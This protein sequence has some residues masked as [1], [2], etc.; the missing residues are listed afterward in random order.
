MLTSPTTAS[1]SWVDLLEL[2]QEAFPLDFTE[3]SFLSSSDTNQSADNYYYMYPALYL[4]SDTYQSF[5]DHLPLENDNT[6]L[7]ASRASLPR[8]EVAVC[9]ICGR[10]FTRPAD[11]K[12][13]HVVVH[14][15]SFTDCPIYGCTRKGPQGF[16][17]K[18][19]MNEHV[20]QFHHVDIKKRKALKNP[21]TCF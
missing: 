6:S 9:D 4:P 12:R 13:H 5:N 1:E 16:T 14:S 7:P 21:R 8:P 18:D 19:H 10:G 2:D 17:R 15:P 3:F 11:L 20:R